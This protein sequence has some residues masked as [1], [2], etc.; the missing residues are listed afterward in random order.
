MISRIHQRNPGLTMNAAAYIYG[1][2]K[3]I[4]IFRYLEQEDKT[5]LVYLRSTPAAETT[6]VQA[7]APQ[8]KL[9]EAVTHS[10]AIESVLSMGAR[11]EVA[12]ID[13]NWTDALVILNFVETLLTKFLMDH[14]YSEAQIEK[15][16]WDEK[17]NKVQDKLYEEARMKGTRPRR[18]VLSNLASYRTNRNT[19]DHEAHIPGGS[20]KNHEVGL[21]LK[22]LQALA[23]EIFDEHRSYCSLT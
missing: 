8:H 17:T 12:N 11:Y 7:L 13:Q 14:G 15:M 2:S 19:I 21:L 16:H 20:I 1:K 4:S 23:R 10:R 3:G 6:H 5:S 9:A 22:L 18:I